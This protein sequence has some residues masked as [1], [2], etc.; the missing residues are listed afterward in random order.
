MSDPQKPYPSTAEEWQDLFSGIFFELRS[1]LMVV[2]GYAELIQEQIGP[3]HAVAHNLSELR[4]AAARASKVV[5]DA[6]PLL[7][8]HPR[9][10]S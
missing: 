3:S 8:K 2:E 5:R 1:T 10:A 6:S 4:K 9:G 7:Y